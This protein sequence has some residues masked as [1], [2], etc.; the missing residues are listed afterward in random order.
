MYIIV[1]TKDGAQH[2]FPYAIEFLKYCQDNNGGPTFLRSNVEGID[3]NKMYKHE[4]LK[5]VSIFFEE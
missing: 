4:E 5:T 3:H 2:K 1:E